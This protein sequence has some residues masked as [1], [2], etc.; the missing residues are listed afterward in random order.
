MSGFRISP[1]PLAVTPEL[2]WVLLR[3]F[4]PLATECKFTVDPK[5]TWSLAHD[6]DLD[7][8]IGWRVGQEQLAS[9]L[10]D[11]TASLFLESYRGVAVWGLLANSVAKEVAG[12]AV[13]AGIE[14]IF[15]K[16]NA[17][18]LTGISEVGARRLSDV[19]LLVD[20]GPSLDMQKMLRQAGYAGSSRNTSAHQLSSLTHRSGIAVEV[21]TSVRHMRTGRGSRWAQAGDLRKGGW[22]RPLPGMEGCWVPVNA[23]LAGHA[24]VHAV[25]QHWREVGEYPLLRA[26]G[27]LLDL[28][29]SAGSLDQLAEAACPW[30]AR[31]CALREGET[32][33]ALAKALTAEGAPDCSARQ[34]ALESNFFLQHTIA[35]MYNIEYRTAVKATG[36]FWVDGNRSAL[37]A[38]ARKVRNRLILDREALEARYGPADS[39]LRL[40]AWRIW[41]PFDLA[42]KAVGFVRAYLR[43]RFARGGRGRGPL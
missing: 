27:D 22:L 34:R 19:D 41:R 24:I 38:L 40:I 23:F 3:A 4:G 30:L 18:L 15:L 25:V 17:L 10:D 21:H 42:R 9:E 20:K 29:G 12:I 11:D 13:R 35:S 1:P 39:P 7:C 43:Y 6:L 8:R 2:E 32:V 14:L 37:V 33:V 36:V 31:E 26:V 16:S 28:A 5:G